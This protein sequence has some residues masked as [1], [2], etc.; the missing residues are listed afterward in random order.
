[1][2]TPLKLTLNELVVFHLKSL[3]AFTSEVVF[4]VAAWAATAGAGVTSF[5]QLVRPEINVNAKAILKN[6]FFI[7]YRFFIYLFCQS[8]TKRIPKNTNY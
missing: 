8:F 5:I 6:W 1:L 4:A 2:R 7:F 3:E